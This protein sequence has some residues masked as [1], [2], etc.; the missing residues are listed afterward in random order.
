MYCLFWDAADVLADINIDL[1]TFV[2]GARQ[3]ERR[4][5]RGAYSKKSE[6]SD[7]CR[8]WNFEG[9]IW[10]SAHQVVSLMAED[11]LGCLVLLVLRICARTSRRSYAGDAQAGARE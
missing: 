6:V 4:G 7:K 8:P 9:V 10:K 3:M 5:R 11:Y 2:A 1:R